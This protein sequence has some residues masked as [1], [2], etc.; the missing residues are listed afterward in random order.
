M[1]KSALSKG[2]AEVTCPDCQE[3]LRARIDQL[4]EEWLQENVNIPPL[5]LLSP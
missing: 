2:E 4:V 5:Q 3:C 1:I